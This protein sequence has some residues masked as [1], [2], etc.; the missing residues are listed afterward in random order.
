MESRK[1]SAVLGDIRSLWWLEPASD[2][3]VSGLNVSRNQLSQELS[4]SQHSRTVPSNETLFRLPKKCAIH[5]RELLKQAI[6]QCWDVQCPK[7]TGQF[8]L[9]CWHI[10]CAEAFQRASSMLNYKTFNGKN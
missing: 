5:V 7:L 4:V 2:G 8:T 1:L 9:R 6:L 10:L 3:H